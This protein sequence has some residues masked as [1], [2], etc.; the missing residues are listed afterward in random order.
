MPGGPDA[1]GVYKYVETDLASPFSDLLNLGMT[2]VSAGL[3]DDRNRLAQLEA[4]AWAAYTPSLAGITLG[5][6]TLTGRYRLDKKLVNG[7]FRFV[8]G[9]T[10]AF[11]ATTFVFGLPVTPNQS[12]TED[13]LGIAQMMDAS[14]GLA[15]RTGG[16][17]CTSGG[18]T[19]YVLAERVAAG[20][21]TVNNLSPWT[22]ATSDRISGS[23]SY[24][25]A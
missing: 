5:N 3:A 17:L 20:A 1:Q 16:W 4:G 10:T 8:A 2:S 11:T 14:A 12:T 18:A 6:G 24:E 15:S 23:F 13:P 22:W 21:G 25:A 7:R 9:S 19:C